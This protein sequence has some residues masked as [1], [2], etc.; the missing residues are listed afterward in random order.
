M[1]KRKLRLTPSKSKTEEIQNLRKR[2][3]GLINKAVE[4]GTLTC[5]RVLILIMGDEGSKPIV[6]SNDHLDTF[7]ASYQNIVQ[8]EIDKLGS[9]TSDSVVSEKIVDNGQFIDP[10][11]KILSFTFDQK[12][13]VVTNNIMFV[14]ETV[15]PQLL[16]PKFDFKSYLVPL[17]SKIKYGEYKKNK[18][19]EKK[20]T[21]NDVEGCEIVVGTPIRQKEGDV[22]LDHKQ[23]L[24]TFW[25]QYQNSR[26]LPEND[27]A[28]LD[29][30]FRSNEDFDDFNERDKLDHF[31]VL[32]GINDTG[33]IEEEHDKEE[34]ETSNSNKLKI[35]ESL[36]E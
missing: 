30:L 14:K 5:S 10:E 18:E 28:T 12:E 27:M 4:I 32:D 26:V 22:L 25:M 11:S 3:P 24:S 23:Q 7:F 33:T 29:S 36:Y 9:Q 21:L 6:Y 17:A 35:F 1:G 19:A 31:N 34:E 16:L 8:T 13:S 15:P 2:L 20:R